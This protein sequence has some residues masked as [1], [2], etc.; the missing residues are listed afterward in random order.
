MVVRGC[1]VDSRIYGTSSYQTVL[2]TFLQKCQCNFRFRGV[3]L[4]EARSHGYESCIGFEWVL[5][6]LTFIRPEP[7]S[8]LCSNYIQGY[9]CIEISS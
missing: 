3:G 6:L 7:Q 1:H 5:I 9:M 4:W 8:S 2:K